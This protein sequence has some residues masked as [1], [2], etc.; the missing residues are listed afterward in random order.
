MRADHALLYSGFAACAGWMGW[1]AWRRQIRVDGPPDSLP[2]RQFARWDGARVP[3]GYG[4]G[5]VGSVLFLAGGVGDMIWHVL[6]GIEVGIDALYSPTRMQGMAAILVSNLI[7]LGPLLYLSRR[8]IPPTGTATLVNAVVGLLLGLAS[9]Y[10]YPGALVGLVLGGLA[11]DVVLACVRP[12]QGRRRATWVTGAL[13]PMA[14][15]SVYLVV[16]SLTSGIAW[17]PNSGRASSC[18]LG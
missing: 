1:Q 11:A 4:L 18:G 5:L 15:W 10:V 3:V 9:G 16:V 12:G 14:T 8:W 7:L 6:L 2:G 17:P 13:A